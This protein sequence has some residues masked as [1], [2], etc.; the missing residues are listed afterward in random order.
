MNKGGTSRNNWLQAGALAGAATA[1]LGYAGKGPM[2]GLLGAP[3]TGAGLARAGTAAADAAA[4]SRLPEAGMGAG[5]ASLFGP[6]AGGASALSASAPMGA[7]PFITE[8]AAGAATGANSI[9]G[10][11]APL[12]MSSLAGN[13]DGASFLSRVQG[14]PD[15][16]KNNPN[17]VKG[18]LGG[19][20]TMQQMQREQQAE[21]DRLQARLANARR[22]EQPAGAVPPVRDTV[23]YG[24][25]GL[26]GGGMDPNDPRYKQWLAAQ[27]RG[28]YGG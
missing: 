1:G 4:A 20:Q 17:K 27:A 5:I 22:P 28:A 10:A 16:L 12:G 18:L 14:F 11:D 25:Q 8:G 2:A 9:M 23:I 13:S 7:T 15:W 19:M 3:E 24:G 6:T 26:L 21:Q